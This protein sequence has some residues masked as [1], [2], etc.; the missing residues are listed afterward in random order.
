MRAMLVSAPTV[1]LSP[2]LNSTYSYLVITGGP[3]CRLASH[4]RRY[5][6][7]QPAN[8]PGWFWA[9]LAIDL[10]R[11]ES[12]RRAHPIQSMSAPSCRAAQYRQ[13]PSADRTRPVPHVSTSEFGL[14]PRLA[15]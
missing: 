7:Q 11:P 14:Q 6:M 5:T 13:R 2:T 8:D 3:H 1:V 10:L 15:K 4:T 9:S 12:L